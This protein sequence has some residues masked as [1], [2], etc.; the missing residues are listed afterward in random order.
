M[1]GI[2]DY[3]KLAILLSLILIHVGNIIVINVGYIV[4]IVVYTIDEIHIIYGNTDISVLII[5]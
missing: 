1:F 4:V 2:V 5:S 3:F